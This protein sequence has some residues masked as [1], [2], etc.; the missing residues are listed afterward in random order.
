MTNCSYPVNQRFTI[1]AIIEHLNSSKE[2]I[3]FLF[4]YYDIPTK[5][6]QLDNNTYEFLNDE[7]KFKK[8]V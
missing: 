5:W 8:I 4:K 7:D 3:S 2:K 6:Y 1:S